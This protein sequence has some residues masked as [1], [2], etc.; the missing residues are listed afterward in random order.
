M[1]AAVSELITL[2]DLRQEEERF[3]HIVVEMSGVAEPRSVRNMFQEAAMYD[4]PLMER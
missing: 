2:S 4:M 1:L 3:D